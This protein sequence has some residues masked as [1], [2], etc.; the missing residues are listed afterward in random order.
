LRL[1]EAVLRRPLGMVYAPA[2]LMEEW[3]E[4][5]FG[6]WVAGR[7]L[8]AVLTLAPL[9][10]NGWKLRQMAVHP[11]YQRRGYG[12]CLIAAAERWAAQRGGR[13]IVLHARHYAVP[14]Y[15]KLGYR[16]EGPPFEEVGMPHY[17][18]R[19]AL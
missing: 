8:V 6:W 9:E 5:H 11:D 7:G 10:E 4:Y 2:A 14:F 1:R 18:M 12:R 13:H 3:R 16:K 19:K 17:R 15:E